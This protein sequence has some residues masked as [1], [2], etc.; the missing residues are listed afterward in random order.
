M[1]NVQ[2]VLCRST[3]GARIAFG[4]GISTTVLTQGDERKVEI[5]VGLVGFFSIEHS[6]RIEDLVVSVCACACEWM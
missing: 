4:V 5:P 6:G 1:A 2:L 3:G